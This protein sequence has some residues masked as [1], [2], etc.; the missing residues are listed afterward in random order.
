MLD[1]LDSSSRSSGASTF[2]GPIFD[3]SED[4]EDEEHMYAFVRMK[5][6]AVACL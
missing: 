6:F 5:V 2:G 1:E 4:E 3:D